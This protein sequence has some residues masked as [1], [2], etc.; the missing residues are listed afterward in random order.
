M[1]KLVKYVCKNTGYVFS[2]VV[3][4]AVFYSAFISDTTQPGPTQDLLLLPA[5]IVLAI[6][7][8]VVVFIAIRLLL[9]V[10]RSIDRHNR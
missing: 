2:W 9:G 1:D 5:G 4:A 7:I 6:A 3:V 8:G 10:G